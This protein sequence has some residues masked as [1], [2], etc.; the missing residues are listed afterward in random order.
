MMFQSGDAELFYVTAGAGPEV[1]LLHPTPVDHSFWM[2]MSSFLGGYRLV[3]PDLRGHGRSQLGSA[4]VSMSVLA[5][6]VESLLDTLNIDKAHFLGCSI[7]GYVLYEF[8]R[9]NSKRVKSL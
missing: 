1:V 4:P 7:G 8:W 9:L 6:D 5:E 2:P 3:L